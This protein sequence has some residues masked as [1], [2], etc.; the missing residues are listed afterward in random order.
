MTLPTSKRGS[1]NRHKSSTSRTTT[2]NTDSERKEKDF[3]LGSLSSIKIYPRDN[4]ENSSQ[5]DLNDI[6]DLIELPEISTV[7]RKED[8]FYQHLLSIEDGLYD[9]SVN[10][11]LLREG[12]GIYNTNDG[13]EYY[14]GVWKNDKP[15]GYGCRFEN[16][17]SSIYHGF[18]ENQILKEG[19]GRVELEDGY[20]YEGKIENGKGRR[21]FS[22]EFG[23]IQNSSSFP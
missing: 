15:N 22:E 18:F 3:S 20:V 12:L 6:V 7:I 21:T 17:G 2:T 14:S 4:R 10:D 19:F 23:P 13:K 1:N 11:E 16:Y 9:G 8:K 5:A